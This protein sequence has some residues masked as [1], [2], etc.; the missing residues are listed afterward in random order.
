M[1]HGYLHDIS[2]WMKFRDSL[3]KAELGPVYVPRLTHSSGDIR[4]SSEEIASVINYVLRETGKD[5]VVL[6]GHSMGGIVASYCAQHYA[7]EGTVKAVIT[8]GTPLQGTRLANLGFGKASRQ[9]S[10]NSPFLKSLT[11]QMNYN[12]KTEYFC[13]GSTKDEAVKPY[14]N[15]FYKKPDDL[16]H[17]RLYDN[18]GHQSFLYDDDVINE[19][20]LMIHTLDNRRGGDHSEMLV[21]FRKPFG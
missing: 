3:Q 18:V 8:I 13:L 2:G 14:R 1:V 20:I 12:P 6:I 7:D 11:A 9:M 10:Y 21:W 17:F 4:Y 19:V 16:V 15:A 5:Q